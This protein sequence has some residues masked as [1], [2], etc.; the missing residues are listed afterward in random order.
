MLAEELL[1]KLAGPLESFFGEDHRFGS[2]TWISNVACLV[3]A[4]HGIPVKALPRASPVMQS[5]IEERECRIVDLIRVEFQ[6]LPPEHPV[7]STTEPMQ[8][9]QADPDKPD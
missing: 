7:F 3:Q 8:A 2:A 1:E 6:V 5:E 4:L 9:E